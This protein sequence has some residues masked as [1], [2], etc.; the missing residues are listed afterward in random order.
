[1]KLASDVTYIYNPDSD[2][3]LFKFEIN[4]N[5]EIKK[6][7]YEYDHSIGGEFFH[8]DDL[9][10]SD[11]RTKYDLLDSFFD[12]LLEI[13]DKSIGEETFIKKDLEECFNCSGKGE[14]CE[15]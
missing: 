10:R 5:G 8:I 6:A 1:M 13:K 4:I 15:C 14:N 11:T 2:I 9:G 12:R 3:S 7:L